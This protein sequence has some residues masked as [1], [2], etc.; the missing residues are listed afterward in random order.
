M[1][2]MWRRDYSRIVIPAKA[3]IH[4]IND[5]FFGWI[6]AFAGMTMGF[7]KPKRRKQLNH[8]TKKQETP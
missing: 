6:P 2:E 8:G 4:L 7:N 1:Q 5:I 3:G